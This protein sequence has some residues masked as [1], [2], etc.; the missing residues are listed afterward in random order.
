MNNQ[1]ELHMPKICFVIVALGAVALA[2][3]AGS[4]EAAIEEVE[5][6][7]RRRNEAPDAVSARTAAGAGLH[8]GGAAGGRPAPRQ[9]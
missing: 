3:A 1:L 2:G 5:N 6:L 7:D 9:A 4:A 8:Q